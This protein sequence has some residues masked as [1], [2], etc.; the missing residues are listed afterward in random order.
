MTI[1]PVYRF[2]RNKHL[3]KAA[4]LARYWHI[5][6]GRARLP[7]MPERNV[8]LVNHFETPGD[9][10]V[11]TELSGVLRAA[12]ERWATQQ[13]DKPTLA[14]AVRRLVEGGLATD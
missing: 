4:G 12:V 7:A 3:C 6:L 5:H 14:E 9:S 10:T 8:M 2:H 11:P 1:K 13:L